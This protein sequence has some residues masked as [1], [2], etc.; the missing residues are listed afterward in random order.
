[1]GMA[2][3]DVDEEVLVVQKALEKVVGVAEGTVW[4]LPFQ[5]WGL[6]TCCQDEE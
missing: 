3:E 5:E 6:V 1:M 4:S 2:V